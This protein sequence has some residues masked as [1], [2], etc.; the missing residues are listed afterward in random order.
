MTFFGVAKLLTKMAFGVVQVFLVTVVFLISLTPALIG[1]ILR[2]NAKRQRLLLAGFETS[3]N[4]MEM[5]GCLAEDERWRVSL[6][7]FYS[8]QF[9]VS[10]DSPL[11]ESG[12]RVINI[13]HSSQ[14]KSQG[15][16]ARFLTDCRIGVLQGLFLFRVLFSFDV[17]VFNWTR[18]FLPANLDYPLI[19]LAGIVLL[20]RHC[21]DDVRYRP[22][23]NGIHEHFGIRQ[24]NGSERNRNDVWVKFLRQLWAEL[25]G[26]VLSTR[27]HATFQVGK[28]VYRPYVQAPLPQT[29]GFESTIP[30]ILHAPSDPEIKGTRMVEKALSGLKNQGLIFESLILTNVPHQQV[31]SALRRTTILIDQPGA[32]PARLAVEGMASGCA[33]V[34][35]NVLEIHGLRHAPIIQ[36]FPD[37][38]YL[39]TQL[40]NL[41]LNPHEAQRMG[42]AAK[43][44]A[45]ENFSRAGFREFLW[46]ATHRKYRTFDPV[47]NHDDLLLKEAAL[48]SEKAVV[49]T[50]ILARVV[51]K[52]LGR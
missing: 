51:A 29:K 24:W 37:E 31:L 21:G 35:G 2:T 4:L 20:I 34:G 48:W 27:D 5:A 49:G 32:V 23:Q 3:A 25:N 47:D 12:V 38:D 9:F 52:A 36:F 46:D 44:F 43:K 13:F 10:S 11:S 42:E 1:R 16:W 39:E 7:E 17:V 30:F 8:N 26:I 50:L 45:D 33:V 6:A 18:S 19:R 41:I 28:L 40:K 22:L 14:H 15:L